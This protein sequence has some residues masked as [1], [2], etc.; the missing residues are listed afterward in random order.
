[1]SG[2]YTNAFKVGIGLLAN[3]GRFNGWGSRWTFLYSTVRHAL[4]L[5]LRLPLA[6]KVRVLRFSGLEIQYKEFTGEL[7]NIKTVFFD[8]DEDLPVPFDSVVLDVGANIGLF[9]LYLIHKYGRERFAR[10]ELFEPNPDTYA[11]LRHN[12]TANGLDDLC[13]AHL[14]AL[15]DRAGTIYM[16]SPRGYSVLNMI[17]DTGTVPVEC[18]TLDVWARENGVETVHLL[19]VDVEGHEMPLLRGA[20]AALSGVR[21]LYIEVKQT[22]LPEFKALAAGAG[23]VVDSQHDLPTGD[24]MLMLERRSNPVPNP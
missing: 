12:L 5:I 14:L 4:Y 19:K 21:Y 3:L 7:G 9:T 8:E 11:R 23:F 18:K 17:S 2:F 16:E 1:M 6:P 13:K 10:I 24:S 20:P 22:H 15:S